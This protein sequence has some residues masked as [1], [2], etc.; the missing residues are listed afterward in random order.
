MNKRYHFSR[1]RRQLKHLS[2]HLT[3]LR[4]AGRAVSAD[5]LDRLRNLARSLAPRIGSFGV[6]RALGAGVLLLGL[7][8]NVQAQSFQDPQNAPFNLIRNTEGTYSQ[9]VLVDIDGD[10][11]LDLFIG[12]YDDDVELERFVF[13][14]NVGTPTEPRFE[15]P[16]A[17]P[18]GLTSESDIASLVFVDFDGDGDLDI[19]ESGSVYDGMNSAAVILYREN[20]GSATEPAFAAPVENP[21]GLTTP[22]IEDNELYTTFGDL[23]GDGDLDILGVSY[24]EDSASSGEDV[25]GFRIFYYENTTEDGGATTF[26]TIPDADPFGIV[27]DTADGFIFL[28]ELVDLDGDGDLDLL[29]TSLRPGASEYSYT[30]SLLYYENTGTATE[31]VFGTSQTMDVFDV[32]SIDSDDT[33]V[34]IGLG[35]LDGDG[36]LDL[37]ATSD[38]Q[39]LIYYRNGFPVSVADRA[40]SIDLMVFP[41]PTPNVVTLQTAE[42]LSGADVF[43]LTGRR[44]FSQQGNLRRLDLSGLPAGSYSLR[45]NLPDGRFAIRKVS[46]Q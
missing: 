20:T 5:Q 18:F 32:D 12:I 28:D 1:Q 6:R 29:G 41:N 16:V 38:T 24:D 22:S 39:G 46:K 35:D 31:P 19:L 34:R 43:D 21:F 25:N 30:F 7:G 9:P 15:D 4:A 3:R 11:D 42:T 36:D 10:G 45:L 26:D 14:R 33:Q 44:V 13:Q 27:R 17:N 37:L 8:V 2:K 23:D 40:A